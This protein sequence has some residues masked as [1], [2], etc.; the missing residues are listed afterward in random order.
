[1][2]TYKAQ[3]DGFFLDLESISDGAENAIAEYEYPFTNGNDMDWLGAR[4]RQFQ[5][6][7]HFFG[8]TYADF[9]SFFDY[10]N[11][12]R[13]IQLVHP[14]HGVLYGRVKTINANHSGPES[15]EVDIHFSEQWQGY[16]GVKHEERIVPSAEE[17]F[18][19]GQ[20]QQMQ[21]FSD[22]LKSQVGAAR[23]ADV[24]AKELSLSQ[25]ILVQYQDVSGATRAYLSAI[26][27]AVAKIEASMLD[28]SNPANSLIATIDFGNALPGRIIG[29]I[30]RAIERYSEAAAAVSSSPSQ[31]I[32]SVK[33]GIDSLK[34]SASSLSRHIQSIGAM[35]LGVRVAYLYDADETNRQIARNLEK[36]PAWDSLGNFI[37]QETIAPIL[38]ATELERSLAQ[39]REQIQLAIDGSRD[40]GA[41]PEMARLLL[42]HVNEIKLERERIVFVDVPVP[43]P[44]HLIC[45]Q[46]GLP[47]TYA[48][49]V[50]AINDKIAN[51]S[52]VE[53]TIKVYAR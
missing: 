5:F 29:S 49:R 14:V 13:V 38:T 34:A 17:A 23:G 46:R 32:A 28:I 12:D 41:L 24:L 19:F 21:S 3:L 10:C 42:Y 33:S 31:F 7:A 50:L 35:L 20:A 44:L 40:V 30:A 43:T 47:Y 53:G 51:P 52:F 15:V 22:E 36:T 18:T 8:P 2:T 9:K 39:V 1:M 27:S 25:R 37:K 48:D 26:D 45:L 4:S 11:E 16:S 6:R